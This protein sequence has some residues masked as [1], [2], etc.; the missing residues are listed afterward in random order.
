MEGRVRSEQHAGPD[1]FLVGLVILVLVL[2][3][4]ALGADLAGLSR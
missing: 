3:V 2:T 1:A 4:I